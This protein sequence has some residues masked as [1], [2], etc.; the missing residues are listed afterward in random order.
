MHSIWKLIFLTERSAE[1]SKV[2]L[3]GTITKKKKR[4]FK[5][6]YWMCICL[7]T[8]TQHASPKATIQCSHLIHSKRSK[9]DTMLQGKLSYGKAILT[10]LTSACLFLTAYLKEKW[11]PL[12]EVKVRNPNVWLQ[13]QNWQFLKK[14]TNNQCLFGTPSVKGHYFF[15]FILTA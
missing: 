7:R 5:Y 6:I 13:L 1:G 11:R 12:L 8:E 4:K 9:C 14:K 2:S 3:L 10:A 15:S